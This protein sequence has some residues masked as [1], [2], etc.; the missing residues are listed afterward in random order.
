[1]K[2]LWW[3]L[4]VVPLV[5]YGL[6]QWSKAQIRASM[7]LSSRI[8]LIPGYLDLVH[9]TNRGAA[10]G[11]LSNAG[12]WRNIFFYGIALLAFGGIAFYLTRVPAWD[13]LTQVALSLVLGGILGN[14]TDRVRLNGVTDFVSIHLQNKVIDTDFFG[15][16]IHIPLEWPAFNV[17]DSAITIAMVLLVMTIVRDQLSEK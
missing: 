6:D 13:R 7:P 14:I 17:A 16:P 12:E 3:L 11:F 5:V 2:R 10:F 9:I 8:E 1:M 15:Y 4:G